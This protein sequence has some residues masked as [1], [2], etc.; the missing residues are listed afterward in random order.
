MWNRKDLKKAQEYAERAVSLLSEAAAAGYEELDNWI[1]T[2]NLGLFTITPHSLNSVRKRIL[3]A[4][5]GTWNVSTEYDGRITQDCDPR[6]LPNAPMSWPTTAIDRL[7]VRYWK[8]CRDI[9]RRCP[10]GIAQRSGSQ[11]RRP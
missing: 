10:F 2:E 6:T 7:R 5:F 9:W 1:A 4:Y 3:H 8:R 11:T